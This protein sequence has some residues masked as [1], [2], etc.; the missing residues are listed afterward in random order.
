MR[1]KTLPFMTKHGPAFF[2]GF[3]RMSKF[4]P[5]IERYR[6]LA[7]LAESVYVF[8]IPDISLPEIPNVMYI[9]LKPTDQLA[10]EWF[11]VSYGPDYFS[12]LATEEITEIDDP[13][14][15]RVF[16][17]IWTF[18]SVIVRILN[19]W[20][21]SALDLSPLSVFEIEHNH[22]LQS[23]MIGR[24]LEKVTRRM[25]RLEQASAEDQ[26]APVVRDELN[27]LVNQEITPRLSK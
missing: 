1:S 21:T 14:D 3:Q 13:D 20:L 27:I 25:E 26:L 5:Q 8:G 7:A 10:R 18:D 11:L 15:A 22:S 24:S 12:A 16:R 23:N 9:P 4:T 6:K 17:G 19:D 2:S